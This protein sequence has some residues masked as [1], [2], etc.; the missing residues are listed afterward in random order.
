MRPRIETR[1]AL[2]VHD[3][4]ATVADCG[5][6][7]PAAEAAHL[8]LRHCGDRRTGARGRRCARGR[9]VA[10]APQ[11]KAQL[12]DV[13]AN[14]RADRVVLTYSEPVNH[15]SDG[16][17]TFP[18]T[19]AGYTIA[20]VEGVSASMTL[21]ILLTEK[22]SSDLTAKPTVKYSR[23]V[24][25]IVTDV[26]GNEAKA[27]TFK[28]TFPV[29]ALYAAPSGSDANPGTQSL[30][31]RTVNAA[32]TAA[33]SSGAGDVY[34]AEGA[35]RKARAS[36]SPRTSPSSAAMP[37]RPGSGTASRRSPVR[38]RRFG[39]TATPGSH[40]ATSRSW[41][42]RRAEARTECLPTPPP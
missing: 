14:G 42:E 8:G 15:T 3:H 24:P 1:N 29:L 34:L 31:K 11:E 12:L 17:G 18:F 20:S 37:L 13:D 22:A 4:S 9:H 5:C 10:T 16:D 19:V 39:S 30:P 21:T 38:P 40:F 26:A 35:M 27:E 7:L 32:V 28:W 36:S 2:S 41:P 33:V 23:G 6:C 25:N